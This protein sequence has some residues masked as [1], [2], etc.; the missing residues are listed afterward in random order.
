MTRKLTLLA[1]ILISLAASYLGKKALAR[2]GPPPAAHVGAGSCARL[3]SMAPSITEVLFAL[4]LGERVAGV[5]QFCRYPPEA[6]EKRK[7]GAYFD[8]NYEAILALAPDLVVLL[9][10]QEDQRAFLEGLGLEVLSVNHKNLRGIVESLGAVGEACG[11]EVPAA[12][13]RA[14]IER[15]I[16]RTRAKTEGLDRPR[17][18]VTVGRNL[19]SESNGDIYVSGRDGFY[20]EMIELAG[21]R[22]IFRGET[23]EFPAV[24][25]EAILRLDPEV[26]IE[27]IP[28]PGGAAVSREQLI[29]I[30]KN[31]P[32]VSA[33]KNDRVYLF[34]EDYAVIPGPRF[35]KVLEKMARMIHPE[36]DW[37]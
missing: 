3:V 2:R 28:N 35:V 15:R 37:D 32:E 5:T 34:S 29:G 14:E 8:P 6:L 30:W 31:L 11:A 27:M 17:V 24:S 20:D 22:N 12:R 25:G 36:A 10:E 4:G 16:A 33:V 7:V 9:A 1:V 13:I 26:I 23:L 19:G 18:M 21:G